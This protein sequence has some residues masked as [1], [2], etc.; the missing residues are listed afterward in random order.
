MSEHLSVGREVHQASSDERAGWSTASI[1]RL[2]DHLEILPER[3]LP[4]V[5]SPS[6]EAY[7]ARD[8]QD[9]GARLFAL[10]CEPR[11]PPRVHALS[12][13]GTVRSPSL[14][15]VAGWGAVRW[16]GSGRRFAVVLRD[17]GGGRVLPSADARI[18][19]VPV[20]QLIELFLRPLAGL[21]I[22]LARRGV[23]HRGVRPDNMFREESGD[24]VVLG[25]CFTTP[26]GYAQPVLYEPAERAMAIPTGRGEGDAA[27][28]FYA[29][30]ASM[31]VLLNGGNP[32]VGASPEEI[33]AAKMERGSY[34]A[35]VGN[36]ELPEKLGEVLRGLLNDDPAS[37]WGIGELE[38]WVAGGC[39]NPP[40]PPGPRAE[41]S[42]A[43]HGQQLWT[44]RA[45]ALALWSHWTA[46]VEVARS[47]DLERWVERDLRDAARAKAIAL[48]HDFVRKAG[49][50]DNE[51]L[52]LASKLIALDPSGPI[53][54]QG[55]AVMPDGLGPA[56]ASAIGNPALTGTLAETIR[57]Q[58]PTYWVA[59]QA[60][61]LPWM[62][63]VRDSAVRLASF[64]KRRGPF[65]VE[66]CLYELNPGLACASPGLSSG[67]VLTLPEMMR[68]LDAM[69]GSHPVSL[70]AHACA[71]IAARA[72]KLSD[73]LLTGVASADSAAEVALAELRLLAWVQDRY[74][75]A[76]L[77]ALSR[78]FADR[79]GPVVESYRNRKLRQKLGNALGQAA[80]EGRLSTLLNVVAD[81]RNLRW[82][83]AAYRAARQQYRDAE[84]EL[85]LL[86]RAAPT[87]SGRAVMLGH[88]LAA[89]LA[90]FIALIAI[91]V[92]AMLRI[93]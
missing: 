3:P 38:S 87:H 80:R 68:T 32:L 26:A 8:H 7:A 74:G 37:R 21:L 64:M 15:E 89:G 55:L 76:R 16:Q 58:L 13:M 66:R 12:V 17:P 57:T 11:L 25:E 90:S 84:V 34:G 70:D 48:S 47:D 75:P 69:A 65:T 30:G 1:G 36:K 83:R 92:I 42:F 93:A 71:F 6:T 5:A 56:L 53:R 31:S 73:R 60:K 79:L 43:F 52:L 77:D 24:R 19:P 62:A 82:D 78:A 33:L 51:A 29:L 63:D 2:N 45:L 88:R 39:P 86:D 18:K 14:V 27:D 49:S 4:T 23:T 9:P 44:A 59:H 67:Y 72:A 10:I 20:D 40:L 41:R 81:R 46:A 85:A 22:R 28:D 91:A 61:P 54:L 50:T 35:I